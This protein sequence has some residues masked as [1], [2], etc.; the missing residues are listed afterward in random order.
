M[1]LKKKKKKWK[2]AQNDHIDNFSFACWFY[3]EFSIL[4]LFYQ[5]LVTMNS[6]KLIEVAGFRLIQRGAKKRRVKF[7]GTMVM[8]RVRVILWVKIP[9]YLATLGHGAS[10]ESAGKWRQKRNVCAVKKWSHFDI[11]TYMVTKDWQRKIMFQ[12][13]LMSYMPS[14]PQTSF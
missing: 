6:K 8:K 3:L 10:V 11:S 4:A 12:K 13:N 1:L 2:T 7:T 5:P 14:F 9:G